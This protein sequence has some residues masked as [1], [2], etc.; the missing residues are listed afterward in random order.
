MFWCEKGKEKGVSLSFLFIYYFFKGD[1]KIIVNNKLKKK[2]KDNPAIS[3]NPTRTLKKKK[4]L[5]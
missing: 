4:T 1:E 2:K 3:P 5:K